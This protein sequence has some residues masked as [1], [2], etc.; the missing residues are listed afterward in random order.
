[1]HDVD[2]SFPGSQPIFLPSH[3][4]RVIYDLVR[5]NGALSRTDVMRR[6]HLTFPS[7]SRLV[8]D[9]I[10]RGLLR[11]GLKRR[12]GMGKPPTELEVDEA[13]ALSVG[14]AGL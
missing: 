7:V 14:M 2:R 4:Q 9:L 12:G 3:N 8:D 6:N 11:E 10:K 1:M 13:R 5:T